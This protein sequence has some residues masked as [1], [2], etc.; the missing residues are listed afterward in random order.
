MEQ[1][2]DNASVE[3]LDVIDSTNFELRRRMDSLDNLSV[4]AA[5]FQT[6]GRGQGS[7]IWLSPEDENLTFSVLLRFGGTGISRLPAC[8]AVRITQMATLSVRSFL[9]T[10][11]VESRIKWPNDIWVGEKKICGMLIENILDGNSVASSILGIG[12]NL[13]Q[14]T[15]DPSLPNPVSLSQLTGRHYPLK[16][17]L[18]RIYE[19]ICRRAAQL[20]TTDGRYELEKEFEEHLFHLEKRKQDALSEAIAD[21]EEGRRPAKDP[22]P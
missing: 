19:E 11:G 4:I 22:R 21:F 3:W 15:F 1:S 18:L 7:H 17:T 14:Q 16:K 13:N 2:Y 6:A 5:R 20:D 8:E 12:I 9:V 10:E